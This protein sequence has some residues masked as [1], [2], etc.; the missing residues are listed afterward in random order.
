MEGLEELPF[1]A[2]KEK[3]ACAFAFSSPADGA[4]VIHMNEGDG[5]QPITL[6]PAMGL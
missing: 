6:T 1:E 3:E 4:S 2:E 5:C